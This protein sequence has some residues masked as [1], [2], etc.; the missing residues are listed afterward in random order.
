MG[1]IWDAGKDMASS[2]NISA[3]E[4][5]KGLTFP[6]PR[7]LD[8]KEIKLLAQAKTEIAA[9]M[10]TLSGISLIREEIKPGLE[11]GLERT[12]MAHKITKYSQIRQLLL[13]S[14]LGILAMWQTHAIFNIFNDIPLKTAEK[15][16]KTLPISKSIQTKGNSPN[17]PSVRGATA[18]AK[19]YKDS[20]KALE[21]PS[22][23]SDEELKNQGFVIRPIEGIKIHGPATIS[24]VPAPL[25]SQNNQ[26]NQNNQKNN[27]YGLQELYKATQAGAKNLTQNARTAVE[28][29]T[30]NQFSPR[31][32]NNSYNN[33]YKYAYSMDE[34]SRKLLLSNAKALTPGTSRVVAKR[35]LGKPNK[36]TTIAL[37]NERDLAKMLV[38]TIKIWKQGVPTPDKDEKLILVFNSQDYLLSI[39]LN[40]GLNDTYQNSQSSQYARND[41]NNTTKLAASF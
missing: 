41:G 9:R 23:L 30:A 40:N 10:E 29:F 35:V 24:D 14:S 16:I 6:T 1:R 34:T 26:N 28:T 7:D 33:S 36:E 12:D 21:T 37:E 32:N 27:R 25:T 19:S 15:T 13:V 39:E 18:L 4:T 20:I 11:R 8:A 17:S 2:S 5:L 38:Y 22:S 31:E 3:L